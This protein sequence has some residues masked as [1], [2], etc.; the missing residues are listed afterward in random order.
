M[1]GAARPW[2]WIL[3]LLWAAAPALVAGEAPPPS[4][5]RSIREVRAL[6]P[7]QAAQGYPVHIQATVTHFNED[8]FSGMTLHDGA[9][10]QFVVTPERFLDEHPR[11]DVQRGDLVELWGVTRRGGFAPNVDLRRVRRLGPGRMPRAR[12]LP[13]AELLSGRHDCDYVEIRGVAQRAWSASPH[14]TMFLDVAV[15]G[16][17]VR[18]TFWD[19]APGD[20]ERFIDA[21]VRLRGSVGTLFTDAGQLRGVSLFVGRV[22]DIVV[23]DPAPDPSTLHTRTIESLYQ[24]SPSGEVDRRVRLRGVVTCRLPGRPVELTDF[25][26]QST[27]RRIDHIVYIR[28]QTSGARIETAEEAPL[29]PGDVVDVV[30][31]PAVT[32]TKPTLRNA[33]LR[34]LGTGTE[35]APVLLSQD[36]LAL[37]H[38][39]ELVRL[40]GQLLGVVE[41]PSE[42][43]L[44]VRIGELVVEA[45]VDAALP[46]DGLTAIR[47]GSLIALTGVYV[48]Q[49]GPPPS[50]RILLRS[51]SDV[52]LVKAAPWWTLRH[53]FVLAGMLTL[54]LAL[55]GVWARVA[56]NRNA[57]REQQYQAILAERSRLARELHDTLE[58]G[59]AGVKLQLEAV[60]GSLARSPDVARGSLDV[61]REMLRYCLDEARRSVMDLRSQALEKGGLVS[62]LQ[63]LAR[64]MTVGTPLKAEVRV[65]GVERRLDGAQEHHLLRIGLEALT[66]AVKHAFATEIVIEVRYRPEATELVVRDNGRG[67]DALDTGLPGEHFG[68]RGIRERVDKIGG[69]LRLQSRP[70]EGAE[71]AV[72]VPTGRQPLA[73]VRGRLEDLPVPAASRPRVEG[74]RN[75]V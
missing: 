74:E 62:A 9:L 44:V 65:D 6:T 61:A 8:G 32:P 54:V 14:R 40:S 66:N 31:F 42:R 68:M 29:R 57:L 43:V 72:R 35:P 56:A 3:A 1:D 16:G 60:A 64:Q 71:V 55:A 58:Q 36:V 69:S 4:E 38:D 59:L 25:S 51:A 70:G 47:P 50:F 49:W 46:T 37:E 27:F 7:Q 75:D 39:A 18:A 15:E 2:L 13:F 63:E 20:L 34:K 48:F 24:Y 53:S 73:E 17:T 33:V 41:G 67:L 21:R 5:L 12:K 30:G 22:S 45:S 23:E 19:Y 28:D 52:A 11:P 26:T 10:G